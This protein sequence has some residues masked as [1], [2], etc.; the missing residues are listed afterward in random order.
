[1]LIAQKKILSIDATRPTV[2][3]VMLTGQG[4]EVSVA[5]DIT[6]D[7]SAW[8]VSTFQNT[9]KTQDAASIRTSQDLQTTEENPT[10]TSF[11]IKEILE[12]L[13]EK[14]FTESVIIL[15]SLQA[16]TLNLQLPFTQ[17]SYL[18]QVAPM[19]A[20]DKLPF[21]IEF[22]HCH[23]R[24]I[25]PPSETFDTSTSS[26][27]KSLEHNVQVDLYPEAV[28]ETILDDCHHAKFEPSVI[29][30]PAA[31]GEF[32]QAL[33]PRYIRENSAVIFSSES[34]FSVSVLIKGSPV[35]YFSIPFNPES[36]RE[37][38]PGEDLLN[39]WLAATEARYS[40]NIERVYF[41]GKSDDFTVWNPTDVKK[42]VELI[43]YEDLLPKCSPQ[44]GLP[45]LVTIG[46]DEAHSYYG[47]FTPNYRTGKFIFRPY[48][49]NLLEGM[50]SLI[51]PILVLGISLAAILP[52]RFYAREYHIT[53]L[54]NELNAAV[55]DALEVHTIEPG[56]EL[57]LTRAKLN[58][59]HEL[60]K[61]LGTS[62][63]IP[64]QKELA[65]ILETLKGVDISLIR[66]LNILSDKTVIECMATSYG[67]AEKI[68]RE[69]RKSSEHFCNVEVKIDG[70]SRQQGATNFEI[71][72]Q[73]A[74]D[75]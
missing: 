37:E 6:V 23:A 5:E 22:F 30:I 48:L 10:H 75:Q 29:T 32:C 49:R 51:T 68:E 40:T 36:S 15:P 13:A 27:A 19:E 33:Y 39:V 41:I 42:T 28:I 46:F 16:L 50:R 44:L 38:F 12:K 2:R 14:N 43:A 64:L 63:A 53:V 55:R 7:A 26:P 11:P 72:L 67:V 61:E 60:L 59:T 45:C 71:I 25:T 65:L 66:R 31:L 62:N 3:A 17:S 70:T 24:A 58:A 54:E 69:F 35:S 9:V 56:K 4:P 20:Q 74:C 73:K 18:A 8:W 57:E 34:A 52:I 47:R 1:V 21:P